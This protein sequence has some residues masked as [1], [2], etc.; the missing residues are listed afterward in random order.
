MD[1][2]MSKTFWEKLFLN[3]AFCREYLNILNLLIY[4][5]IIFW[6]P[7]LISC[8]FTQT[9]G[10]SVVNV[11]LAMHICLKVYDFISGHV[12]LLGQSRRDSVW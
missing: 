1:E 11:C 9:N 5:G 3:Y 6:I 10:L 7:W 12:N 8:E 4:N 2:N